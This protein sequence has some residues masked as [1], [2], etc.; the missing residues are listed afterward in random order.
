MIEGGQQPRL[1]Q[2]VVEVP[3]LAVGDLDRDLLVDPLVLGQ[4]DRAEPAGAQVGKDLVLSDRLPQHEHE[5][6]GV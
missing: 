1:L 3:A 2:E 6:R 5:A 4:E